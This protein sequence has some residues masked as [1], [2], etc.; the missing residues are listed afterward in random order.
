MKQRIARRAAVVAM[1]A[2]FALGATAPVGSTQT[3]PYPPGNKAKLKKCIKKAK[4]KY[5][6]SDKSDTDKEK[7]DKRIASCKAKFG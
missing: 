7:R 6:K 4:K 1:A 2:A 3:S 5:A